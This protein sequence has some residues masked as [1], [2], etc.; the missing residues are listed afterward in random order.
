MTTPSNGRS[1]VGFIGLG[2]QGLPMAE[3]IAG[4]GFPVHAWARRPEVWDDPR[5]SALTRQDSPEALA[6]A[7]DILAVCVNTDATVLDLAA[8]LL[9]AMRPGTV[10]VNHG[11][12]T[13][14]NA[15][16]MAELA[17]RHGI[18]AVDAPVSGGR[19]GA[20]ARTLTT[21]A[22][23]EESAIELVRP[24]LQS[25]SSRV[26]HLGPAGTGQH[27]KLFNNALMLMNMRAIND[28]S[29]SPRT[30]APTPPRWWTRCA[31]AARP[32]APWNC[33]APWS[34]RR[35]PITCRRSACS[36]WR[37]SQRR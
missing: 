10:F 31:P 21:L 5:L 35:P 33:W 1:V 8:S 2:D 16:A 25:F 22:G 36:T 9:P 6:A 7:A 18:A 12:G 34:G 28:I 30:P 23:G 29:P 15:V 4:A 13:P 27:A 14:A 3:A 20:E 24:V 17:A 19:Q 11:T 37:S 26:V 32:A